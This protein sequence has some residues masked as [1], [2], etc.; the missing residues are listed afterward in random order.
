[1]SD[2]EP[3]PK[4]PFRRPNPLA[5]VSLV[6]GLVSLIGQCSVVC[7]TMFTPLFLAPL[8]TVGLLTGWFGAVQARRSGVGMDLA[9]AGISLNLASLLVDLVWVAL[10]VLVFGIALVGSL[11]H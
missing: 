1:V 9:A 6:L 4:T 10:I 11:M 7:L 5:T 3:A 8:S 2:P